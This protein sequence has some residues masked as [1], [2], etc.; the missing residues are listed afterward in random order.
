MPSPDNP[1]I[2]PAETNPPPVPGHADSLHPSSGK[3]KIVEEG[4]DIPA[5]G[6]PV[7][8][9]EEML[10]KYPEKSN[11]S[12]GEIERSWNHPNPNK[13]D[14]SR[15]TEIDG[16]GNETPPRDPK[17]PKFVGDVPKSPAA[18]NS[19]EDGDTEYWEPKPPKVLMDHK[20]KVP[21]ELRSQIQ[22][23]AMT[24]YVGPIN[25]YLVSPLTAG[26][27]GNSRTHLCPRYCKA[28]WETYLHSTSWLGMER[29]FGTRL[30][31]LLIVLL[32]PLSTLYA[33][34]FLTKEEGKGRMQRNSPSPPRC[35]YRSSMGCV[36]S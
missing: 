20:D 12:V 9:Q 3:Q 5:E 14:P 13:E 15:S 26:T 1:R 33:K 10:E 31:I 6:F 32:T 7:E 23:Y 30:Y 24:E 19:S 16:G 11:P 21:L 28:H 4:R 27:Q 8:S 35:I 29:F 2:A 22:Q 17:D 18:A 36:M 34:D 25:R